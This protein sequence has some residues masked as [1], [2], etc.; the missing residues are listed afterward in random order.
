MRPPVVSPR[1]RS[2]PRITVVI[3]LLT[4][5]AMTAAGVLVYTLESAR[6]DAGV[7]EQIDQEIEE[8]RVFEQ[9]GV[10]PS[11][12]ERFTDVLRV[13]RTFLE[14]NVPD[15]DEMLVAYEGGRPRERS[16]NRYGES[17][18]DDPDYERAVAG[19]PGRGWHGRGRRQPVRRGVGHGGA[20]PERVRRRC[21]G[22]HQ[23]P[24]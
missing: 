7:S 6:I 19:A 21:P 1:S 2:A 5:A 20:G 3:A 13:T 4:L 9:E 10:D 23:L 18:L 12:G 8:F 15:D 11:T 22:D 24:R 14:R 17:F 16:A